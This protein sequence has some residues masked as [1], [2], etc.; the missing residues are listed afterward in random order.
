MDKSDLHTV[1]DIMHFGVD[2]IPLIRNIG[3]KTVIEI[4]EA[5]AHRSFCNVRKLHL[6]RNP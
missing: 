2:N 6:R 1:E 3:S 5:I 4:K